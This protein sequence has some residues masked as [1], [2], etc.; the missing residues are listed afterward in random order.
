MTTLMIATN[1]PATCALP[2]C[3]KPIWR[4][5]YVELAPPA[6]EHE[7]PSLICP[8]CAVALSMAVCC[9]CGDACDYANECDDCY[10]DRQQAS[11]ERLLE[12][13]GARI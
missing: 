5:H 11:L 7:D 10:E 3:G 13:R 8:S 1:A 6:S 12:E 4:D 2:E 9:T